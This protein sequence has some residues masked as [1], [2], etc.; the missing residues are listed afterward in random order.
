MQQ[1]GNDIYGDNICLKMVVD[2]DV[3]EKCWRSLGQLTGEL[4]YLSERFWNGYSGVV[5][6]CGKVDVDCGWK[7]F[8]AKLV[9]NF[10][11][12]LAERKR[13][14]SFS[15]IGTLPGL[16]ISLLNCVLSHNHI[17]NLIPT[18]ICFLQLCC[19]LLFVIGKTSGIQSRCF[20]IVFFSITIAA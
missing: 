8:S 1:D 6:K 9:W 7:S 14:C 3:L 17:R 2:T 19:N 15:K 5:G 16:I 11:V 4:Q 13:Q 20:R 12:S 10:S 18:I